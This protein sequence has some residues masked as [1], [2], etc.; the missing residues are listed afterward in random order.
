MKQDRDWSPT[1]NELSAMG[2]VSFLLIL[3]LWGDAIVRFIGEVI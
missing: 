1:K 3:A 2:C